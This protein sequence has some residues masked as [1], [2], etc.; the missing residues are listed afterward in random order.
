MYLA[1]FTSNLAKI[2]L[3][4]II[5]DTTNKTFI[6]KKIEGKLFQV[7]PTQHILNNNSF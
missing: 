1:S 4:A 7:N 5:L 6:I 2:I 3:F